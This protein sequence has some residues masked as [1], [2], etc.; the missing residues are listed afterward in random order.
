[1][2]LTWL[3]IYYVETFFSIEEIFFYFKVT[4]MKIREYFIEKYISCN[5]LRCHF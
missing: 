2:A 1:M 3:Y 4:V 5:R